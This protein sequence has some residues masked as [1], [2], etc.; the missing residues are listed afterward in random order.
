MRSL[1]AWI[2]VVGIASLF[3]WHVSRV[4]VPA[5]TKLYDDALSGR[6]IARVERKIDS[7]RVEVMVLRRD[8]QFHRFIAETLDAGRYDPTLGYD[9]LV[10]R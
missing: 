1:A 9:W 7:L 8:L 6:A 3:L 2:V 4:P 5:S 10:P